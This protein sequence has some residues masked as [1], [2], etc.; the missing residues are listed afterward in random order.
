MVMVSLVLYM[1]IV[2]RF[3]GSVS[4]PS[5]RGVLSLYRKTALYCI[6]LLDIW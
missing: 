4:F 1:Q 2:P 3:D 6:E 5:A